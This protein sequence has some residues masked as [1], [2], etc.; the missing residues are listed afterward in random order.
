MGLIK[1]SAQQQQEKSGIIKSWALKHPLLTAG[2][3]LTG[4]I[5]AAD[6]GTGMFKNK[7]ISKIPTMT[8][9]KHNLAEGA[10]YGGILSTAEPLIIHKG[11]GVPPPKPEG[12]K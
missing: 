7:F 9:W 10:V 11:L 5:A 1:L 6:L 3:G 4:G 2:I 12:Q 8:N